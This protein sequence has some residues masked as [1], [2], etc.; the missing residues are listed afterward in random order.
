MPPQSRRLPDMTRAMIESDSAEPL[1]LVSLLG[2]GGYGA[3]YRSRYVF[4]PRA[5]GVVAVKVMKKPP[6]RSRLDAMQHREVINHKAVSSHPNIVTFREC[7]PHRPDYVYL[8]MD[9]CPGGTLFSLLSTT[10]IFARND[11]LVKSM[12]LQLV[13]AIE[14]CHAHKVFHRD[15]KPENVLV[16]DDF[17]KVYLTDFGLSTNF[18]ES[19]TFRL[20]SRHYMSPECLNKNHMASSYSSRRSDIW[21]LGVIIVNMVTGR[22]P[23]DQ[24]AFD[25]PCF[26][27][28]M[29][30]RSFLRKQLPISKAT[31][32]LLRAIFT[33]NPSMSINLRTLKQRIQDVGT[34]FMTER[35]VRRATPAVR[36]SAAYLNQPKREVAR[37]LP[38]PLTSENLPL[39]QAS[40]GW[41][42]DTGNTSS[43]ESDS[44][45]NTDADWEESTPGVRMRRALPII[46]DPDLHEGQAAWRK[47]KRAALHLDQPDVV[48]P[49]PSAPIQTLIIPSLP[50]DVPP[51]TKIPSTPSPDT[52]SSATS[53]TTSSST[54]NTTPSSSQHSRTLRHEIIM[55]SSNVPWARWAV[56]MR[57]ILS[58]AL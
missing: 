37:P 40:S 39:P 38:K 16:N 19:T 42:Y 45:T 49:S 50:N 56:R 28:Y 13:S 30:N 48:N 3:V 4:Q 8:I 17:T 51:E 10:A 35:E 27:S 36:E 52:S 29:R 2:T 14:F 34:F 54:P 25:D 26:A 32:G 44:A 9:Y 6:P 22:C 33:P 18:E 5:T 57:R 31:N 24:A 15:L 23:W 7:I 46:T 47:D 12:L 55:P 43:S 20:G 1:M 41:N 11:T 58:R 21:A 53:S